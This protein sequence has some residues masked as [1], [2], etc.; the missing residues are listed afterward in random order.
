MG[1]IRKMDCIS[2]GVVVA[3]IS[4]SSLD[5][6]DEDAASRNS[7][8]NPSATHLEADG[9]RWYMKTTS[10]YERIKTPPSW[11]VAQSWKSETKSSKESLSFSSCKQKAFARRKPVWY[12]STDKNALGTDTFCCLHDFP[13]NIFPFILRY[14]LRLAQ[15]YVCIY[16]PTLQNERT[17]TL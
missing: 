12:V 17:V 2:L 11:S 10:R 3:H 8:L 5:P 16:S 6:S 7:I 13:C 9:C 4:R 1:C 14:S 15:F